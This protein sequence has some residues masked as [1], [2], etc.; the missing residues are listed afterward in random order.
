[1]PNKLFEYMALGVPVVCSNFPLWRRM[2]EEAG[3]GVC[4]DPRDPSAIA[5][6]VMR[7]LRSRELWESMSRA[8]RRLA[9][10]RYNWG[11]EAARLVALYRRLTAA[12]QLNNPGVSPCNPPR[13]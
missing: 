10:T 11:S 5:G 9:E 13:D 12:P 6:A 1:M 4:A 2:V 7:I 3:A 8:G